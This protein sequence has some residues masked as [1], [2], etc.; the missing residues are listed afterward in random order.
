MLFFWETVRRD[1]PVFFR[2]ELLN[3]ASEI[4]PR[5]LSSSSP[6][7]LRADL[8]A[9]EANAAVPRQPPMSP[10]NSRGGP[11][12]PSVAAI[13]ASS[14]QSRSDPPVS[15][16]RGSSGPAQSQPAVETRTC[17][18]AFLPTAVP[19][20]SPVLRG[21][22]AHSCGQHP[23]V[24]LDSPQQTDVP[25]RVGSTTQGHTLL[26]P[27]EDS[28]KHHLS[29]PSISAPAYPTHGERLNLFYKN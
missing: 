11:A 21:S 26:H 16:V 14:V 12:N 7:T 24:P 23:H 9:A 1:S 13:A 27:Q 15:S 18:V 28:N 17:L 20:P 22:P 5:I 3:S 2:A 4:F 8:A 19:A 6:A 29:H 10:R 25:S